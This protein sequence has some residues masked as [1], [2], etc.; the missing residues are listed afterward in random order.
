M[1]SYNLLGKKIEFSKAEDDFYELQSF[2]WE[3]IH[4]F[5]KEYIEWHK[6]QATILNVLNNAESFIAQT[7]EKIVLTPIYPNLAKK[8][9][10]Y[11]ISKSDYIASCLDIS[12]TDD[13]CENAIEIYNN[14][15]A[16]G[17]V[18]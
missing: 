4:K 11:G 17:Q 18:P 16:L 8:Y 7:M 9:E 1:S 3:S 13:I 2:L 14:A 10:L 12:A 5:E 6:A 15:R